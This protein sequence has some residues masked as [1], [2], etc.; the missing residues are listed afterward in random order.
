MW[1][2]TYGNW[3]R[4]AEILPTSVFNLYKRQQGSTQHNHILRGVHS[5]MKKFQFSFAVPIKATP[6]NFATTKALMSWVPAVQEN[7]IPPVGVYPVRAVR[8]FTTPVTTSF[9]QH[10]SRP[11][12]LSCTVWISERGA[13]VARNQC[14]WGSL[15]IIYWKR[16]VDIIVTQRSSIFLCCI[17]SCEAETAYQFPEQYSTMCSMLMPPHLSTRYHGWISISTSPNHKRNASEALVLSMKLLNH[18]A[19]Q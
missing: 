5:L 1:K 18:S 15:E 10:I 8:N 9:H 12:N 2:P 14:K 13:Y 7:R 4:H 16:R 19:L 3:Q 17:G 11:V 6:N